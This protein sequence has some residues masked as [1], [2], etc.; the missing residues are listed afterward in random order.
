MLAGAKDS[1]S[2]RAAFAMAD[3]LVRDQ[4]RRDGAGFVIEGFPYL[5]AD[6]FSVGIKPYIKTPEQRRAWVKRLQEND[7]RARK[8]E[9]ANLPPPALKQL[10]ADLNVEADPLIVFERIRQASD[11][12]LSVE[13]G[14][15]DYDA[16]LERAV[17]ERSQYSEVMRWLGFYPLYQIPVLIGTVVVYDEFRDWHQGRLADLPVLGELRRYDLAAGRPRLR[18][19]DLR[20]MFAAGRR[21]ELAIPQLSPEETEALFRLYAPVIEQD[22]LADYDHFGAVH[23]EQ[24]RVRIRTDEPMVYTYVTYAIIKDR[25][26]VQLNYALWYTARAG[27]KAPWIEHGPLDGLTLR[28]TLDQDGSPLVLD[29]MNNCGCYYFAAPRQDKVREIIPR[30][31]AL[32][33]LVPTWLPAD[34]PQQRLVLRVNSGWHQIEHIYS[35]PPEDVG[36]VHT[37]DLRDYALLESLPRE[38]GQAESVFNPIGIMKDSRRIEPLFFFPMGIYDIGYM[39]Q[40]GHHAIKLIGKAHFSDPGLLEDDFVFR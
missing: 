35:N 30:P 32:D 4:G 22:T 21:D 14:L 36:T 20:G 8:K 18:R 3:A 39:R 10:A 17:R 19:E 16:L 11:H 24:G 6:F 1:Q 28:V 15:P 26:V 7:L 12:L 13:Q 40:R 34:Y 5:R 25:P 27:K 23:W 9:I 38:D 29:V 2:D 33:P 31:W 37:Y